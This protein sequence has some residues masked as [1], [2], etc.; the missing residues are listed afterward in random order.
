MP[1]GTTG[2]LEGGC[3]WARRLSPVAG[4]GTAQAIWPQQMIVHKGGSY[5]C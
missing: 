3:L 4:V 2:L 5:V 1:D